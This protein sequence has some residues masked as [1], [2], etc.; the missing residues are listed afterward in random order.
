MIFSISG[1]HS[2]SVK[3]RRRYWAASQSRFHFDT[4]SCLV[5]AAS[6]SAARMGMVTYSGLTGV[7]GRI[8]ARNMNAPDMFIRRGYHSG[9]AISSSGC[10]STS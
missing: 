8:T 9:S 2:S 3:K 1:G 7:S 5:I 4:A 10:S 6:R